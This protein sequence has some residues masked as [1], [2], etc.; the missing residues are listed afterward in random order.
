M[1][2]Q[3]PSYTTW[4]G[5]LVSLM[6]D[7]HSTGGL[8]ELTREGLRW[9]RCFWRVN[10]QRMWLRDEIETGASHLAEPAAGIDKI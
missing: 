4:K 3:Y 7:K 9:D 5:S 6:L 1:L 10:I 8:G 2:Q